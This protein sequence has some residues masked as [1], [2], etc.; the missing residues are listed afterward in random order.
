MR[1]E[2]EEA[3]FAGEAQMME[4]AQRMGEL[5]AEDKPKDLSLQRFTCN[6]EV[7]DHC[8]HIEPMLK[9]DAGGYVL[10]AQAQSE[11]DAANRLLASALAD[12]K[13]LRIALQSAHDDFQ[14][15]HEYWNQSENDTAMK[16]A[17]WYIVNG[18][19][20]SMKALKSILAGV[21][22]GE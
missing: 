21:G 8:P 1:D 15:F 11:I 10:H 20:Q 18:T 3:Y 17:L 14:H 5:F 9:D 12:V 13:A 7:L 4:E 19:E 22:G 6:I 16:D 2:I